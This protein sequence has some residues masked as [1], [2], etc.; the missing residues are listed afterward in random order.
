MAVE[1]AALSV[2][3]KG[4]LQQDPLLVV[5]DGKT[6]KQGERQIYVV[7]AGNRRL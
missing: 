2:A 7:V 6:E 5:P 3:A 4:F 1:E